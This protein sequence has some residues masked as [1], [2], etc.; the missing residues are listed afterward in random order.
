MVARTILVWGTYRLQPSF[1]TGKPWLCEP[2]DLIEFFEVSLPEFDNFMKAFETGTYHLE[3]ETT[4]FHVVGNLK[5]E[6][7]R[8]NRPRAW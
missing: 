5:R 8:Y 3:I 2:F 7:E 1:D 6:T 4:I